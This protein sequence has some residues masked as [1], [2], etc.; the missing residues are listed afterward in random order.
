MFWPFTVWINCSSDLKF[1]A[2]SLEFKKISRS[3]E[4]FF[5]TVC[6]NN[7]DNKIPF[8]IEKKVKWKKKQL[9]KRK[10][11]TKNV[12]KVKAECHRFMAFKGCYIE[13]TWGRPLLLRPNQKW[14]PGPTSPYQSMWRFTWQLDII[15]GSSQCKKLGKFIVEKYFWS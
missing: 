14:F 3:L 10:K 4:Q 12:N 2:F 15:F 13:H 1:L 7:F 11:V 5:L 6:Q 9:V 8:N